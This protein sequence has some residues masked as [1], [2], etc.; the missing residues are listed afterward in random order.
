MTSNYA[1]IRKV[2]QEDYGKAI[3]RFAPGLLVDRYDDRSHFIYELLQNAEDALR[4]RVDRIGAKAVV[5]EL[6]PREL[7]VSHHGEPFSEVD[8]RAI[9]G[10][11]QSPSTKRRS[12]RRSKT[13]SGPCA[14]SSPATTRCARRR[15]SVPLAT[16]GDFVRRRPNHFAPVPAP[17]RRSPLLPGRY[18]LRPSSSTSEHRS[19]DGP[20]VE[21][22][23]KPDHGL[24][25]ARRHRAGEVGEVDVA[26]AGSAISFAR[27]RPSGD[28][29]HY[30][31]QA[32]HRGHGSWLLLARTWLR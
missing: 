14:A 10:I 16:S 22:N 15:P 21:F 32:R 8:V 17:R 24:G 3:G 23:E 31:S 29:R 26:P 7:R 2:N 27:Q 30:A 13:S 19:S 12:P 9:C 11:A 4:R 20:R 6:S 18:R 28:P 1:E 5:F 25:T